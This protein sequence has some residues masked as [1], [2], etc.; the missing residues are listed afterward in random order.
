MGLPAVLG[1]CRVKSIL[2]SK[3]GSDA[4]Q[5][6]DECE[7]GPRNHLWLVQ[8]LAKPDFG[9]CDFNINSHTHLFYFEFSV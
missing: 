2:L 8:V 9:G 3:L 1:A 7:Q 4:E 5:E 6:Q